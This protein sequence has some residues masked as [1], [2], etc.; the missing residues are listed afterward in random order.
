VSDA[1]LTRLERIFDKTVSGYV[2]QRTLDKLD[3][4]SKV[5]LKKNI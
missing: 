5:Q 3:D 4:S 2:S 1:H